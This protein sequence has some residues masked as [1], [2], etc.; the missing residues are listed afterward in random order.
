MVP[1][2]LVVV[3]ENWY[4]CVLLRRSIII[5]IFV[6]SFFLER[7]WVLASIQQHHSYHSYVVYFRFVR[8]E[9]SSFL[10]Y[11]QLMKVVKLRRMRTSTLER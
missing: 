8:I 2:V 6:N 11:F 10:N 3:L 9:P 4:L 1:Y 5:I 7:F